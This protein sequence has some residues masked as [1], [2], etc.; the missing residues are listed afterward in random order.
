[1][2]IFLM[3]LVPIVAAFLTRWMPAYDQS[4]DKY[5]LNL[6]IIAVLLVWA[7]KLLPARTEVADSLSKDYPVGAVQ[8]LRQ[9]PQPTGMFNDYSYGGY[10]IWQLGPQHKVF[11]DGRADYV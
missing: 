6:L 1:M 11:I 9:H 2:L 5:A 8:Y 10:L 4:T 7:V 3:V